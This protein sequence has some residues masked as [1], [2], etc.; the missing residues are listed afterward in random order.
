MGADTLSGEGAVAI[1]IQRQLLCAK[2][3]ADSFFGSTLGRL[4]KPRFRLKGSLF[5]IEGTHFK[6]VGRQ[7]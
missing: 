6:L 2:L 4:E 5:Q 3:D 7:F 1:A